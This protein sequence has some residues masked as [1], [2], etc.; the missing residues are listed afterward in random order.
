MRLFTATLAT[1]TNTFSPLP[2]SLEAYK[3]S[4]FLRP[5]EHPE[6][7]AAHVH[8]AAVRRAPARRGG[9]VHADRGQLLRGEPRRHHQPGRL[10]VH[11]RRDPG[12]SSR[13]RCRSTACC[14][15][16]TAPWSRT[17]TTTSKAT[18]SSACAP[19][20]APDCVIG[21]ELDPHCH[22]TL[23]RVRLADII[24]CYKEFPHT[25][26]VERAEELLDLVLAHAARQDQAGHVA[27]RLPAD[28]SYP[29]DPAADAR[30][31]RQDQGA[32]RARTASCRSPSCHCFPYADVPEVGGR[33]PR[34]HRR[35]QGEGGRGSR[36]SLGEEFVAM[37]GKTMPQYL[38]DADAA[39][40]ARARQQ[41]GAR[42]DGRPG[43]QRRRR[44][45][46]R[47]YHHPA[48]PDRAQ[49]RGRGGRPDLGSDRR[50]ALLRRR[51]GRELPAAL[52]RQ[53]RRRP[54]ASRSTP[55][56]R[57]SGWR[58]TAGRASA[59]RRCRSATA[60]PSG[61]AASRWC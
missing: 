43:R 9:G 8:R 35:R 50:A 51:R 1:E 7:R 19:S 30:L 59:R 56:S 2:T 25:D 4:V 23:K 18:S 20:S 42:G 32:W 11:A 3:E 54:P 14:S 21:V 47:Q 15:A 33:D 34:D 48:P 39:I 55:R 58:A 31:R 13:R 37:R 41:R 57:W 26:V 12:A 44:R 27:L 40:T 61:S 49:R 16:C 6:R 22:L 24:I 53:D 45:A 60:P 17:A 52:R 38:D 29:D 46:L 10:R 28:R 36:A 5:G